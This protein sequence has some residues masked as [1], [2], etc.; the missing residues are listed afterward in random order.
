MKVLA[1]LNLLDYWVKE[2]A[3]ASGLAYVHVGET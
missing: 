1:A 3:K 2:L